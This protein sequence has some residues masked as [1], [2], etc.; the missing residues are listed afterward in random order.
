MS[1]RL[2]LSQIAPSPSAPALTDTAVGVHGGNTDYQFT[3]S[4]VAAG[5][6][7]PVATSNLTWTVSVGGSDTG[8]VGPFATA[9]YAINV[10]ASYNYQNLYQPT[11]QWSNGTF[12][13]QGCT[14]PALLN[15]TQI[16]FSF[17]QTGTSSNV[18]GDF[19]F[20]I[21][22]SPEQTLNMSGSFT[23]SSRFPFQPNTGT[24]LFTQQTPNQTITFTNVVGNGPFIFFG[25]GTINS[26]FTNFDFTPINQLTTFSLGSGNQTFTDPQCFFSASAFTIKGW[27]LELTGNPSIVRWHSPKYYKAGVLQTDGSFIT[28]PRMIG[29]APAT[30]FGELGSQSELPGTTDGPLQSGFTFWADHIAS[31]NGAS[32][33]GSEAFNVLPNPPAPANRGPQT[34]D[35]LPNA[36]MVAKDS[37]HGQRWLAVNDTGTPV[38]TPF[39]A[40]GPVYL[41]QIVATINTQ[42]GASYTLALTDTDGIVEMNNAG[43]N[44]LTV[45][46]NATVAFN[47]G[48]KISVVQAGAG[49]TTIAGAVGVTIR[50]VGAISGGQWKSA[51]LYKR[52]TDEWVQING[53]F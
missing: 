17:D 46:L 23:T 47:I 24:I 15:T 53:A 42:T 48:D 36:F 19:S 4:Q 50:N 7:V 18:V 29:Q 28:G 11:I 27:W 9:Q 40:I 12:S 26:T 14:I 44:T 30:F 5:I 10:A 37:V 35:I 52:G 20:I 43:A 51:L 34:G 41:K 25:G 31:S 16:N 22:L 2:K 8:V 39:G 38:P 49:V 3:W 13:G 1:I 21:N 32:V 33:C 45:P 6:G